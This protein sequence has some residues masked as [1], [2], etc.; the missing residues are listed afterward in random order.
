MPRLD[1]S[2]I[3]S[4]S[5]SMSYDM[6]SKTL[7]F[8]NEKNALNV[9]GVKSLNIKK[10]LSNFC[11]KKILGY[12]RYARIPADYDSCIY[13]KIKY[14]AKQCGI[15]KKYLSKELQAVPYS[16]RGEYLAYLN[17]V[18]WSNPASW[19]SKLDLT[20]RRFLSDK[21]QVMTRERDIQIKMNDIE[22]QFDLSMLTEDESQSPSNE[23]I[24]N[25]LRDRFST[26]RKRRECK[27]YFK[28]LEKAYCQYD[29][30]VQWIGKIM[31]NQDFRHEF[32]QFKNLLLTLDS[33][34]LRELDPELEIGRQNEVLMRAK[35]TLGVMQEK[36]RCKGLSED[37]QLPLLEA[38]LRV[39]YKHNKEQYMQIKECIK[40]LD[41]DAFESTKAQSLLISYPGM[42]EYIEKN[43]KTR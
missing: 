20:N 18:C 42:C 1:I 23:Q 9:S 40:L 28:K 32:Y 2:S 41:P 8:Q 3:N 11:S 22:N 43:L 35:E 5:I 7:T 27:K 17:A 4:S 24:S 26:W 31:K 36:F 37:D 14:L 12:R 15:S 34:K 38:G 25:S 21:D 19:Q 29:E 33:E 16:L 30:E 6:D 10:R 13:I 39:L